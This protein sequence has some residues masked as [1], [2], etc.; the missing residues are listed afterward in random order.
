MPVRLFVGNLPY[1]ATEDEIRAHFSAAGAVQNIF[2]PVDRETGRKRGGASR[3]KLRPD[4]KL[5]GAA[6]SDNALPDPHHPDRNRRRK[7]GAG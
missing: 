1:D 5:D 2:V 3:V 7:R 6:E 4:A